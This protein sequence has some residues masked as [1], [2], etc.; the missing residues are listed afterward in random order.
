MQSNDDIPWDRLAAYLAG[1]VTPDEARRIEVW[2]AEAPERGAALAELRRVW[3]AAESGEVPVPDVEGAIARLRA[4]VRAEIAAERQASARRRFEVSG[5]VA[6]GKLRRALLAAGIAGLA[7][8]GWW[9]GRRPSASQQVAENSSSAIG[10]EYATARGQRLRLTLPDGSGVLLGPESV[11]R[12]DADYGNGARRVTLTGD[13]YFTVTH[14]AA[15]PFEVRTSYAVARDLGTRFVVRARP[16][17]ERVRVVVA[18][19]KVAL[20]ATRSQGGATA[21]RDELALGPS[22]LGEVKATGELSRR[23]GVDLSQLL[24]WTEGRL[25]FSG[26]RLDAVIAELERWYDV[27]IELADPRLAERTFTGTFGDEP[28]RQVLEVV[29]ASLGLRLERGDRQFVLRL[30]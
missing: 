29:S 15:R 6:G 26:A 3:A 24:A 11:L 8:G 5:P 19:G 17:E 12:L 22:D 1:E 28:A 30:P 4:E 2:I 10:R 25:V 14:E 23:H 13:A 16:S 21:S 9:L 20:G 7:L 27:K 18:D